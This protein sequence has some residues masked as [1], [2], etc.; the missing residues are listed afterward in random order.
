MKANDDKCH[1]LLSSP[2]DSA[3]IQMKNS[4]IKCSKVK[5]LLGVHIDY[6]LKFDIH[7]E[8]ICKKARRNL[9]A[10]SRIRNY[11]ELPK[12]GIFMNVFFKA[13]FNYCPII[14]MFHSRCLN[15]KINRLH[16]RCLKMIYNDTISS[17]EELLSKDNSV[18]IRHNNVHALA[19]EMYKA[20]NDMSPDIMNE[21]SN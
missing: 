13:H 3:L 4:S 11:M 15:N 16:E 14:W 1:V 20:A 21:V 17:L 8:T 19:I 9:S 6:K 10:L 2:D 5:N 7:V 12:R 18:T